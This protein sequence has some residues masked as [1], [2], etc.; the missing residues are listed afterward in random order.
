MSKIGATGFTLQNSVVFD[1]DGAGLRIFDSG[2]TGTVIQDNQFYGDATSASTDQF[3]GVRTVAGDVQILR[4]RAYHTNGRDGWGIHIDTGGTNIVLSDNEVFNNSQY[5]LY[6]AA[7]GFDVSGTMAYDNVKGIFLRDFGAADLGTSTG[8]VAFSNDQEGFYLQGYGDHFGNEAYD[9]EQGFLGALGFDGVLRDSIARRNTTGISFAGGTLLNNRAYGNAGSG[10]FFNQPTTVR[11]NQ[12]FSNNYGIR[13][14]S[15]SSSS[16]LENNLIYDN[17]THAILLEGVQSGISAGPLE[18]TNNTV[19]STDS[20][21]IRVLSGSEQIHLKNN[22]ISV[23]GLYQPAYDIAGDSL[24][25]F[26]SDY[27][28]FQLVDG[29]T[30]SLWQGDLIASLSD[31]RYQLNFDT[32]SAVGDPLFVNPTGADGV[33]G[34]QDPAGL[35]FEGFTNSNF[36]GPGV[37]LID[38][39]VN[40][41]ANGDFRGLPNDDQS[42][43]WSGQVYLPGPTHGL[44]VVG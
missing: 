30:I 16:Q 6:I 35:L 23:M 42:V 18:I 38:S 41:S 39:V 29:A 15:T 5:G 36:Q 19:V 22:V 34:L 27:N 2:S 24:V 13:S 43:R 26:Q 32:H 17:T 11:G 7:N 12:S 33:I 9:N 25:G 14:S 21:A 4:N 1:N 3:Y 28:L 10:I 37:T 20:T 44:I 40:V 8:N 31:W